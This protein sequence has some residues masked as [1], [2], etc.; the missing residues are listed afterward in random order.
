MNFYFFAT[1][2]GLQVQRLMNKDQW[3]NLPTVPMF[4]GIGTVQYRTAM[5]KNRKIINFDLI[6]FYDGIMML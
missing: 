5:K 1:S 3:K 4:L 6:N 2:E